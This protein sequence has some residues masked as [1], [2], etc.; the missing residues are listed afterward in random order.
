M[1]RVLRIAL[2]AVLVAALAPAALAHEGVV[3][4]TPDEAATHEA[5][6]PPQ[7]FPVE[8][9][10]RFSL[11]D[12]TG[13]A[14]TEADFAGR[15][16]VIF[17]GYA[18][19]ES[20]CSVAL[21]RIG[22]ALELLGDEAARIAPVMITVDPK[23]DTPTALASTL[24]KHHPRLI[25]LSGSEAALAEARAA[26][27]VEVTQVAATP[28]GAPIYAHGSFI[29]LVGPDGMVKSVLPPILSPERLAALMRKH[30]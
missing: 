25:G 5:A 23:R 21:P 8:I 19:C 14:V 15:P 4:D 22:E 28:E 2:P 13:R 1:P 17:F 11:V 18:S 20:I 3:H 7:P 6:A 29:Y 10:P 12:H 16:M 27:Q 9:T 30:F 24:P 26:F